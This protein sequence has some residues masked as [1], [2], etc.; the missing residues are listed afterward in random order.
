MERMTDMLLRR[1]PRERR[2]LGLMALVVLVVGL[3]LWLIAPLLEARSAVT[4]QGAETQALQLWVAAR[5]AE[6]QQL[7][8]AQTHPP[9]PPIGISALEQSLVAAQLRQQVSRLSGQGDGG[10][11]DGGLELGFEA[12]TF[13]ALA[14][15][16]SQMDPVWGY[17]IA[18]L[19]LQRHADPGLVAAELTLVP[20]S[21]P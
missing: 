2:L 10:Q 17:D 11:G 16:L 3:W 21:A 5:A 20:Q 14:S 9:T 12:V 19:R 15:W 7:G 18:R 8:Q 1:S 4:R 13:T 6:Q